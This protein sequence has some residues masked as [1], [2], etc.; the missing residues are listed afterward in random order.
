MMLL[1]AMSS[2][3]GRLA[4]HG[5]AFVLLSLGSAF[6]LLPIV[7]LLSTAFRRPTDAFTMPP[8]FFAPLT[9][10]NFQHLFQSQFLDD[11][12]HSVVLTTLST[13]VALAAGIPGGYTFARSRFR[14]QRAITAW[15]IGVYIT[16]ALVFMVPLYVLYQQLGLTGVNATRNPAICYD[17]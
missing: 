13:C 5:L 8:A 7:W 17:N 9:L 3:R 15:L 14:G 12:G 11:L 6:I 4:S 16:P 1:G 2:R 10:S